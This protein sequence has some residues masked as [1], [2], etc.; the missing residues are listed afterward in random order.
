VIAVMSEELFFSDVRVLFFA[1]APVA[2]RVKTRFI[3]E[4]GADGALALHKKLML[5]TWQRIS[6][7]KRWPIE[8]W[9][10]ASGEEDWFSRLC[11]V[12]QMFVQQ[13]V[14][15]GERMNF[16]LNQALHRA[17]YVLVVGADCVSLDTEY[18]LDAMMRLKSGANVVLGPAEDGGY[19]LLGV[20]HQVPQQIFMD[21]EWGSERVLQ[22]T[23]ARLIALG[24]QWQELP[25]RW[26]VDVPADLPRL[27]ELLEKTLL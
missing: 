2:G 8:L 26:D 20:S 9:M 6:E 21:I 14:D 4:L 3:A 18:L 16:A 23:R 25:P 27:A 11:P 10:S 12:E 24:I 1:K 13:G 5:L 17:P 22:Q 15:L 19:V 7:G